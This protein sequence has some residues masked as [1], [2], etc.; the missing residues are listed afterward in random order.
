MLKLAQAVVAATALSFSAPAWAVY[1]IETSGVFSNNPGILLYGPI[2][3][4]V[5]FSIN[6]ALDYQR[7]Y[8]NTTYWFGDVSSFVINGQEA[9]IP[10]HPTSFQATDLKSSTHLDFSIYGG[11]ALDP[12]LFVGIQLSF[13]VPTHNEPAGIAHI[14]PDSSYYLT[15]VSSARSRV[16]IQDSITHQYYFATELSDFDFSISGTEPKI[17]AYHLPEPS[18]W[19]LMLIGFGAIGGSLRYK[20]KDLGTAGWPSQLAKS[21]GN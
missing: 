8:G 1:Q 17:R 18:S 9:I 6:S 11:Y 13:D 2:T 19:A 15:H 20:R 12:T 21:A 10:G 4:N 16:Q 14:L 5:K 3:F 7:K